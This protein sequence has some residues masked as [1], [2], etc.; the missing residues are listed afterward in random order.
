MLTSRLMEFIE[1]H[2]RSLI[3]ET[4]RDIQ[5]NER[6]AAFHR[7]PAA[8]L[9]QRV[10]ALF[11]NLRKWIGNPEDDEVRKEYEEWGRKRFRQG[12]PLSEIIYFVIL[13]KAHLRR[14]IREHGLIAFAGDRVTPDELLPVQLYGIQELNYTVGEFFDRALYHLTRGYEAA[15]KASQAAA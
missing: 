2:A 5:T 8:E 4:L 11:L 15:V 13:A 6:T 3:G 12:I 14:F 7:I 1:T 9:E 10:A